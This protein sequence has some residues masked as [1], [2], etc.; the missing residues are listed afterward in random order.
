M[1][2]ITSILLVLSLICY[3]FLPFYVISFQ[4]TITGFSFTAGTITQYPSVRHIAFALLPFISCFLAIGFNTLKNRWWSLLS[5]FFVL[6]MLWF[7]SHTYNFHEI[8]LQHQPDVM[9]NEDI[10]E[11][12]TIVGLGI[13]YKSSC[14]L[15]ILAL[16][17]ALLSVL[18]FS[19]NQTIERA[20][21]DTIDRS[22][23]DVRAIGT[24]VSKDVKDWQ[25][26][27]HKP[28]SGTTTATATQP[29]V[30]AGTGIDRPEPPEID[31]E[32]P[33]R[34]MPK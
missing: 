3:V 6:G 33:S 4:G 31:K 7:F 27:R 23:E 34:F 14:L 29:D 8:A 13:G 20:V 28:R 15:A 26:K 10:G 19:F 18:P 16:C 12:F 32:D 2:P 9:P 25:T 24:R 21:D 5:A 30:E 17:S 1:K 22:L 11:G